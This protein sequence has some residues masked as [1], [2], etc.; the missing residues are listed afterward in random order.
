MSANRDIFYA[1]NEMVRQ[2][3]SNEQIYSL[4]CKV[5]SVDETERT[6][7]CIPIENMTDDDPMKLIEVK[8]NATINSTNGILIIPKIGSYV[9]LSFI[10][11]GDGFISM[12]SEIEKIT[13]ECNNIIYNNGSNNGLVNVNPAKTAWTT[14]QTEIDTL[15]A[16]IA[17]SLTTMGLALVSVDGGTTTAQAA[18]VAALPLPRIDL[19]LIE[20]KKFKH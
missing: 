4:S 15:K 2:Y 7:V 11:K 9:I 5:D 20:D 3:N 6:C 12:F 1:I 16:G 13:I 17:A 18:V 10:N 14:L 19:S 8:L